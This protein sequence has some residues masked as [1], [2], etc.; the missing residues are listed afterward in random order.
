MNVRY[1]SVGCE[2]WFQMWLDAICNCKGT[3]QL[4]TAAN[5]KDVLRMWRPTKPFVTNYNRSAAAFLRGHTID[6]YQ[7]VYLYTLILIYLNPCRFS[8]M[9]FSWTMPAIARYSITTYHDYHDLWYCNEL[10]YNIRVWF[11]C[12]Y[13]RI[14]F[15]IIVYFCSHPSLNTLAGRWMGDD[16]AM[17]GQWS[18][19]GQAMSGQWAGDWFKLPE[20]LKFTFTFKS[21]LNH[22]HYFKSGAHLKR[23]SILKV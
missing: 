17:S 13:T 8:F 12:V 2:T 7:Y 14:S 22:K 21:R 23:Y 19:G 4:R 1:W 15:N 20:D 16:R 10:V 3:A 11:H 5:W 9:S 6:W 18:G